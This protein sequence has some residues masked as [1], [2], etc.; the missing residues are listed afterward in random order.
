MHEG[1]N[2]RAWIH[3]EVAEDVSGG[4]RDVR[5]LTGAARPTI[6][7]PDS[8]EYAEAVAAGAQVFEPLHPFAL[9]PAHNQISFYTWGAREWQLA[10]GATSATLRDDGP[11]DTDPV[12]LARRALRSLA[13]GDVLIFEEVK[14]AA[15]GDP[16]DADPGHRHAV[17]LTSVT[18]S[19]DPLA[20]APAGLPRGVP[21]V[22]I[23]WGPADA[24]PFPLTVAARLHGGN[25]EDVSVARGN[26][27]LADHGRTA[28]AAPLPPVPDRGRFEPTVQPGALTYAVPYDHGR[29]IT[30]PAAVT[31]AQNPRA[32]APTIVLTE[33]DGA[34]WTAQPDL[35]S[36]DRFARDFVVEMDD[37]GRALLRFG[38]GVQG[39]RPLPGL[40]LMATYRLGNGPTGNVGAGTIR[41]AATALPGIVAVSNPLPAAGGAAPEPTEQVRLDAPRA[42]HTQERGAT[43][44]DY[45]AAARRHPLVAQAAA[46]LRWTGSWYTAFIAV[47]RRD[48]RPVDAT[49][50][51]ELRVFLEP[52]RLA[53]SD[54]EIEGAHFVPL[55]IAL[56]IQAA[57]HAFGDAVELQLRAAFSDLDLGGGRRGFFHPRALLVRP[58]GLPLAG[59]RGGLA[60]AGRRASR[61]GRA[62]DPLSALGT[63]VSGRAPTG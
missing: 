45:A 56:T 8:E 14:G 9:S 11:T 49:L 1:S 18:R 4:R 5:F 51:D 13:I 46:V 40:S 61:P 54:L 15:T 17:R 47:T 3:L 31:I 27:V 20:G 30:Q 21:V 28:P 62:R 38:D 41:R 6:L 26:V 12:S 29:A 2:A 43:A 7:A 36:S 22:E 23:A 19:I 16:A 60:G 50:R 55:D 35:L 25:V 63:T 53:G 34:R 44:D 32:A 59:G 33:G 58:A 10:R 39:R 24:L 37:D 52:F 57:P 42:F 48:R